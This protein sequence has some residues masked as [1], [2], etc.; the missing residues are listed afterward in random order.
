MAKSE[1]TYSCLKDLFLREQFLDSCNKDLAT[2]LKERKPQSV[3]EMA[4]YAE[5]YSEA[6]GG[7]KK[8][9][10]TGIRKSHQQQAQ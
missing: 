7:F 8:H 10:H 5:Q 6:H 2:F 9:T 3:K 1:K 4:Q